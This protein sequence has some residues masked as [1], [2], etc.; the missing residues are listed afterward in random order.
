MQLKTLILE[1][2][3]KRNNADG[4]DRVLVLRLRSNRALAWH[5]ILQSSAPQRN[6][7]PQRN[8]PQ[9]GCS[10]QISTQL[11]QYTLNI[12]ITYCNIKEKVIEA[13][14]DLTE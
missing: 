5:S 1:K 8:E 3:A 14:Y 9:V 13:C 12:P 11:H 2:C 4:G 6:G 7:P 10:T